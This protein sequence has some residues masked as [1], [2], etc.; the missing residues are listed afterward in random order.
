MAVQSFKMGPGTL[1]LD[2][3]GT[4]DVSCQVVSCVVSCEENVDA[5]DDVDLLCGEVLEGDED[6]TYSWTL[7]ATLVQDI[8]AAG[9]VDWS[10]TNKGV[11]KTF[12]F[13]PNTAGARKI[14]GT[15]VPV[16]IS[17]GGEA[18]TRPTSD[19]SWRGKKGEDFT[20]AAVA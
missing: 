2:T 20:L 18:K 11:E 16:P 12:E 1:K 15:I 7:E 8:A 4:L 17:V 3:S 9:V 5:G 6:V 19:I 13:I 14:T 10:W